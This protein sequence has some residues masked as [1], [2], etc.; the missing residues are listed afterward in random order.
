MS[1]AN[2]TQV[3]GDHYRKHGIYQPW[4]VLQ[5]WLTPEEYRGWQKGVAI[6]YLARERDK[7]GDQDIE[8]AG[9]HI[10][11]LVEVMT[12]RA[13]PLPEK[14]VH[15]T[16]PG[17]AASGF[18]EA[19]A[20]VAE[21]ASG[22]MTSSF[23]EAFKSG[24]MQFDLRIPKHAVPP[25]H[26]VA[27]VALDLA[28]Q[29]SQT[30]FLVPETPYSPSRAPF[31]NALWEG[32]CERHKA[33]LQALGVTAEQMGRA[34]AELTRYVGK[35]ADHIDPVKEKVATERAEIKDFVPSRQ[36]GK[37]Y[38]ASVQA[39]ITDKD[40]SVAIGEL[41]FAKKQVQETL[42]RCSSLLSTFDRIDNTLALLNRLLAAR[43]DLDVTDKLLGEAPVAATPLPK[44]QREIIFVPSQH[45]LEQ[46]YQDLMAEGRRVSR[47]GDTSRRN[48]AYRQISAFE[49]HKTDVI[50]VRHDTSTTWPHMRIDATGAKITFLGL[51]W[52]QVMREQVQ[53]DCLIFLVK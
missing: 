1:K 23:D 18:S 5:H 27:D 11:K 47:A 29:G 36:L 21:R 9:H 53:R 52:P 50:V 43:Q 46:A 42:P 32:F 28:R 19:L 31:I 2:E 24:K 4:D 7:G 25:G 30:V 8:K 40:I 6:V 44:R 34:G 3:G 14:T 35:P 38:A 10:H 17:V 20:T 45:N 37:T 12:Q 33:Q 49:T 15:V 48:A 22:R 51:N 26:T 16:T 41:E 13:S 39:E